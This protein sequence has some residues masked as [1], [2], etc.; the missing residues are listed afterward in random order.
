M[1]SQ[2]R[3]TRSKKVESGEKKAIKEKFLVEREAKIIN[4]QPKT[5]NQEKALEYLKNKQVVVLRNAS[6]CGKTYLACTHAANELL[7]GNCKKIVL[8]RPYEMVGR[9][10]GLRPGSS[11]DKVRPLMQSMLQYLE[12]VFGKN[13][14]ELKIA[15]GVVVMECLEDV[16]G[17]SYEDSILVV[18][19]AMNV[20]S[21]G[22]QALITRLN[23]SSRIYICGDLA[24]KDTKTKSG[25]DELCEVIQRI[26][27]E[28][29]KYLNEK[30][31]HCAFNNFGIVD[32]TIDDVVR[33]GLTSLMV[34]IID[35]DWKK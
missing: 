25:M 1:S 3:N 9:S 7:R 16:R 33:S 19:E 20:D 23:E 21:H 5:K 28:K 32:F 12:N 13:D 18:D 30:D 24:Q 34:K 11:E 26:K 15:T 31:M 35:H 6:G 10:V 29:P 27:Q 2:R 4:I 14:L 8:I 22:M 17:R